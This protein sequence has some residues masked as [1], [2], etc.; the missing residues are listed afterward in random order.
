M[1]YRE[2]N[3]MKARCATSVWLPPAPP[4][5]Q[6][7]QQAVMHLFLFHFSHIRLQPTFPPLS[8]FQTPPSVPSIDVY[9][10]APGMGGEMGNYATLLAA[11]VCSLV[12]AVSC[13]D[14]LT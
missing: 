5:E 14:R 10:E 11:D 9:S 4:R 7:V 2:S 8:N 1:S 12:S 13:H 6:F 3:I